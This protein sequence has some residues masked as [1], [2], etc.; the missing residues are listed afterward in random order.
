[1]SFFVASGYNAPIGK[2]C[3]K[4][5]EKKSNNCKNLRVS[6][7][8]SHF[9][10]NFRAIATQKCHNSPQKPRLNR[11]SWHFCTQKSRILVIVITAKLLTFGPACSRSAKLKQVSL[12][13][14][15]IAAFASIWQGLSKYLAS[16]SK[17]FELAYTLPSPCLHLGKSM[18][19]H[20]HTFPYSTHTS[21]SF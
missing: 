18:G 5:N 1:M 12:C 6:L 20:I 21:G 11:K 2:L 3:D 16:P 8:Y 10:L 14:R 7:I 13:A 19:K 15:F 9:L 4:G 17:P